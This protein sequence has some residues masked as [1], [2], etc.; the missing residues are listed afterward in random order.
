MVERCGSQ[1]WP[2]VWTGRHMEGSAAL[3][4]DGRKSAAAEAAPLLLRLLP[5]QMLLY[6]FFCVWD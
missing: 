1:E 5:L 2:G 3:R 6:D 4:M